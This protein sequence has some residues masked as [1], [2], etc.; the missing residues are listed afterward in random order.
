M[1]VCARAYAEIG[2][3]LHDF[4]MCL[5]AR[6]SWFYRAPW[7]TP[8]RRPCWMADHHQLESDGTNCLKRWSWHLVVSFF[9]MYSLRSSSS[10]RAGDFPHFD[11][12]HM[13]PGFTRAESNP[14]LN[15]TDSAF[16]AGSFHLTWFLFYR[17]VQSTFGE[18]VGTVHGGKSVLYIN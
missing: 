15:N 7:F 10:A 12:V 14:R 9:V 3:S 6:G 16:A 13:L 17:L 2:C 5:H 8:F 11:S 1:C 18:T 4:G